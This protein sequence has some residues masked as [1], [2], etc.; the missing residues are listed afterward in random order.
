[1]EGGRRERQEGLQGQE[2]FPSSLPF[3]SL[4]MYR[5]RER[6]SRV[7]ARHAGTQVSVCLTL[8]TQPRQVLPVAIATVVG[9]R[10]KLLPGVA[11]A[12]F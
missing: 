2:A 1:M 6:G 4:S 9:K 3:S 8:A 10:D 12:Y 5:G 7:H 11:A